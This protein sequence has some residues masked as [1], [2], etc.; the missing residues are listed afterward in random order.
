MI[1]ESHFK[2]DIDMITNHKKVYLKRHSNRLR[3]FLKLCWVFVEAFWKSQWEI[4]SCRKNAFYMPNV[5]RCKFRQLFRTVQNYISNLLLA[6]KLGKNH[7]NQASQHGTRVI[8]RFDHQKF[9][10]CDAFDL[11]LSICRHQLAFR[12]H[13]SLI[14]VILAKFWKSCLCVKCGEKLLRWVLINRKVLSSKS[15]MSQLSNALSNTPIVFLVL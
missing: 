8:D 15:I 2:S 7:K 6:S 12:V 5:C 1:T 10:I 13:Y 3:K 4:F 11:L 14:F 9:V